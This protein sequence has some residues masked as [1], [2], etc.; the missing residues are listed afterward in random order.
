MNPSPFRSALARYSG[1][2]PAAV[3]VGGANAPAAVDKYALRLD[4][5]P[6][7]S[8]CTEL[9]A[10]TSAKPSP[11]KSA[12]T[13]P[14]EISTGVTWTQLWQPPRQSSSQLAT[15][16]DSAIPRASRRYRGAISMELDCNM[17][18]SPAVW[19]CGRLDDAA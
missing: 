3:S 15:R 17:L 13:T 19:P 9:T 10:T 12:L 18:I 2:S 4:D 16:A 6:A 5:P 7:I 11:L 14:V 1:S 8:G